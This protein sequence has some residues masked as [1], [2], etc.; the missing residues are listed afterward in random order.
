MHVN[1]SFNKLKIKLINKDFFK[2]YKV[3]YKNTFALI[4]KFNTLR[5]FLIIAIMKNLKFYKI[6]VN[7]AF[8]E[9]FFKE[10]IYMFSSLKVKFKLN[11]AL[12][13]L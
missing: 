2:N 5:V 12:N 8:T 4:I 13:V 10:I 7:N 9:S 11:Y 3:N 6:N 1:D